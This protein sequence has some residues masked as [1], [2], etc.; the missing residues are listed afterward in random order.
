M[1]CGEEMKKIVLMAAVIAVVVV[2]VV[3]VLFVHGSTSTSVKLQNI[4]SGELAPNY[5]FLI[6]NGSSANLTSYRGHVTVLWFVATWCSSCAQGNEELNQN[7]QFF[8]EHGIKVVELELYRNLGYSGPDI[9]SFVY[10]YAPTAYANS[11]IIPAQAGYN[12]TVSYDPKGYLDIYYLVSSSGKVLYV[13]S[14]LG[15][16]LGQ[17][18]HAI[19]VSE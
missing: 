10:S 12:M 6:A 11:T 7:Y 18:E 15:S 8:R 19:N 2:A 16:T 5:E 9:A 4:T 14:S 17:L 3:V 13:N 1:L